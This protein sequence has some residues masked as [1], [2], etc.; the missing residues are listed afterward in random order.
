MVEQKRTQTGEFLA[1]SRSP[2]PAMQATGNHVAVA[3]VL[4]ANRRIHRHD[5]SVKI[6]DAEHNFPQQ[7]GIVGKDGG[8]ERTVPAT[9]HGDEI[10]RVIVSDQS[11]YRSEYFEVMHIFRREPVVACEKGGLNER[12]LLPIGVD[13]LEVGVAAKYDRAFRFEFLEPFQAGGLLRLVHHRANFQDRKST[14]LNSSH[15]Y[16][17]YAGFC[18]KKKA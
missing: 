8:H 2:R 16:I 6:A 18:L 17:S 4:T 12:G 13:R 5:P 11:R 7:G 14:R 9:N 3:R 15:G 1:P 10:V